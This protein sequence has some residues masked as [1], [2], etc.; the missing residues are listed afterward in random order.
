MG[1]IA[2]VFSGQ[3]AQY[4]GMG[5]E[6]YEKLPESRAVFELAD[7]LRPG[8]LQQCFSAETEL[9]N[10]TENTQPC[11]FAMELAAAAALKSAGMRADYVAGFSLGE[12]AALSYTGTV[13]LEEGFRLVC[14]RGELMQRCAEKVDSVM[15][16]VVKLA[17]YEVERICARIE[18][19]YPANYNCPGQTA[20]ACRTEKVEEFGRVIKAAGGRAVPIKVRGGFHSPFMAEAAAAFETAVRAVNVKAA[21]IPIYSNCTARPYSGD[22]A[23]LL[24]RQICS[25][26]RWQG[27]VENM[28]LEGVDTFVEIGPGKTLCGLI[29]RIAPA[30]RCFNVEDCA[31]LAETLKGAK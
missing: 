10:E 27:I 12:I 16:A 23:S 7:K 19:T 15:L 3:G 11:M 22:Y 28:L 26:V 18:G 13:S 6:L 17:A 31:S 2:F 24:A 21:E 1:K 20:V 5:R 29:M 4:S 14:R 25:P 8:T 9:L 30:A